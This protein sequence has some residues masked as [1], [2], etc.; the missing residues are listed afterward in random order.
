MWDASCFA[1]AA[2]VARGLSLEG[3]D[4]RIEVVSLD[5]AVRVIAVDGHLAEHFEAAM[6]RRVEPDALGNAR[7]GDAEPALSLSPSI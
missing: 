2:P 7:R 3:D 1:V 5:C 6:C 4:H